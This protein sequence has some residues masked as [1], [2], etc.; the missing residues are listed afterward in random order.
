MIKISKKI[1]QPFFTGVFIL[2]F[3]S[4][5]AQVYQ[6]QALQNI[7]EENGLSDN[8]VQCIFQDNNHF[9]WIGTSSGLNLLNGSDIK[10]FRNNPTLKSSIS[11]NFIKAIAQKNDSTLFIGTQ[12]G[13]EILN[14]HTN[15]FTK[16]L[17]NKNGK[18]ETVNCICS[19]KNNTSFFGTGSG[20]YFLNENN[21][22][23]KISLDDD[24]SDHAKNNNISGMAFSKNGILWITTYNGLWKYDVEN[25]KATHV[26]S[27]RL[28]AQLPEFFTC[29]CLDDSENAWIGSWDDGLIKY[30][31]AADTFIIYPY[32]YNITSLS[33]MNFPQ[34]AHFLGMNGNAMGF[35][36]AANAFTLLPVHQSLPA[37]L[38]IKQ[39][40]V[41]ANNWT[42]LATP[43]GVY[44]Y[45][46]VKSFFTI[47]K[48]TQSIS[49]QDIALLEWNGMILT[50]GG[51]ANFLK[52]Y[53]PGLSEVN[54]WG[55]S[56]SLNEL[57]CLSLAQSGSNTIEAGTNSGIVEINLT[58]KEIV[59]DPL[60][61]L[62]SNTPS[63]NFIAKLLH[64]TNGQWWIFP[65]RNGIWVKKPGE[66]KYKEIF[67]NFMLENN[68][69]KALV[70][71]DAVE[72]SHQNIWMA[73]LDEGII[74]YDHNSKKFSKP[75]Q[76][77]LGERLVTSQIIIKNET[78]YSFSDNKILYWNIDGSN[79]H[80][81]SL[82]PDMDKNIISIALDNALH[83]WL[84]T[85]GGL[86]E[87]DFKSKQFLQFTTSDGLPQNNLEGKLYCMKNGQIIFASTYFLL[88]FQPADIIAAMNVE[89]AILLDKVY[90]NDQTIPLQEKN[91]FD[92]T[93]NHFIFQWVLTDYNNPLR[94]RYYYR[95]AGIDSAW[96][97]AGNKG[98]VEFVNLS[99]GK[100][101][102]QMYG[103]NSNGISSGKILTYNFEINNPFW[104]SWW[105]ITLMILSIAAIFYMLYLFRVRQLKR[106]EHLRNNI[107]LDLHDDIG[108]T[109]SSISIL[110]EMALQEEKNKDMLSEIK[111][112]SLD[113]MERMDDI[114][115]SINPVNDSLEMLLLRIR[116]FSSKLFEAK[117][118]RYDFKISE[119]IDQLH[120]DME[121]R[122]QIYLLLKE[123]VNNMVKYAQCTEAKIIVDYH[124]KSLKIHISDNG[125]GFD[126]NNIVYGNGINS[127]KKRAKWLH[128]DLQ[129]QS[130]VNEGTNIYLNMKI[131]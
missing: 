89:P 28:F 93:V 129:I 64:A 40:Y 117:N 112:N 49:S 119:H 71:N 37:N 65:W 69:S 56:S 21:I 1:V 96:R 77:I 53:S 110:S 33:L 20:V 25:K 80:M 44:F 31:I 97:F 2:F 124:A 102:L 66:E 62:I 87:Y 84:A 3:H 111:E 50:G 45:N 14:T 23:A 52:A 43:H 38:D 35:D 81:I 115:W 103:E 18:S 118:I 57:T 113:L 67:K 116:T 6:S 41:S 73:D 30:N 91:T 17:Y 78:C 39:V 42:W 9:T 26:L 120:I 88:S 11:N 10:I 94:N 79:F 105:F 104:L 54:N 70:I 48:F 114:V 130:V 86:V 108:S 24:A 12:A 13:L 90:A 61:Y 92:H 47:R 121:K 22:P 72:D 32:Q 76:K 82:P 122:R 16:L 125:I 7:N 83:V 101:S 107:S 55:I 58:L 85:Q 15:I 109:L 27:K 68:V 99:P 131:K 19:T 8:S 59:K 126:E 74:F 51:G 34:H 4:S 106:I 46:P 128:A 100:Y 5:F 36:M 98:E 60:N 29:I 63:N 75:F 95:L 123:A 127:M